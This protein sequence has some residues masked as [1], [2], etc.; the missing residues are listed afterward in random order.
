LEDLIKKSE[1]LPHKLE[2]YLEK[3]KIEE[4]EWDDKKN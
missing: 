1:P 2:K 3:G 4:K